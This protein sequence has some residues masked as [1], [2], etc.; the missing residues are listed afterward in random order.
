[1]NLAFDLGQLVPGSEVCQVLQ[2]KRRY[3]PEQCKQWAAHGAHQQADRAMRHFP[4][5]ATV[6]QNWACG[7]FLSGL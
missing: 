2:V 1:M 6:R 5:R 3:T 7:F 4:D